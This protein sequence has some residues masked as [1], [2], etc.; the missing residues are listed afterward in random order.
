MIILVG[1]SRQS[2]P[3]REIMI[4]HN[5]SSNLSTW[6]LNG[7]YCLIHYLKNSF[8]RKLNCIVKFLTS[9]TLNFNHHQRLSVLVAFSYFSVFCLFFFFNIRIQ[10]DVFIRFSS[11]FW[12]FHDICK[13]KIGKKGSLK[14]MNVLKLIFPS[15][16]FPLSFIFQLLLRT[17]LGTKINV[18]R[19]DGIRCSSKVF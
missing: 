15:Q 5:A 2:L 8:V 7:V 10:Y 6:K 14:H 19:A 1:F 13:R 9:M 12:N 3:W 18:K 11:I 16:A 4:I 17:T